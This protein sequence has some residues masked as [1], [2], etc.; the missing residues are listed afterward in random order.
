MTPQDRESLKHA[1]A[2]ERIKHD[3]DEAITSSQV[4]LD[5]VYKV[6]EES[7]KKHCEWIRRMS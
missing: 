5:E 2:L 7:A 4:T 1:K 3:M 6:L